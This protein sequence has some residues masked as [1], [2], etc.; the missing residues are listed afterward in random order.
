MIHTATTRRHTVRFSREVLLI[1]AAY[2]AYHLVRTISA[3]KVDDAFANANIIVRIEQSLG[4]FVELPIQVAMLSY[5]VLVQFFS[6]WYFW[7]HFPL[8]MG[9]AVWAYFRH[10]SDYRWTR[11]AIFI[12]GALALIG[13][14]VF[15]VAPPRLLPA[16]GF[17][18][19]LR[20]VFVL[21]YSDSALVNQFAAMPSMHQGFSL[22]IGVTLYKILG[23]RKGLMAAAVIP[24][25][26]LISIVATGNHYFLDALLGVPV[27]IVGML[28]A[29][30]LAR[31]KPRLPALVERWRHPGDRGSAAHA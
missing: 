23:G 6:L 8:L 10:A 15:P 28:L 16:S 13:Y 24:A 27:A 18:D 25:L 17:V 14:L 4:I 22:I 19:T 1:G 30:R 29:G 11:N 5:D 2:G 12:A 21:Q 7:G 9:F 31:F 3:G 26:M 20:G